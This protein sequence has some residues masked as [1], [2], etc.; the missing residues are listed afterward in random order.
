MTTI[1][2]IVVKLG[3]NTQGL[4]DGVGEA[5][6]V[7]KKFEVGVNK[8]TK[9]LALFTA[10]AIAAGTALGV[11]LVKGS[12]QAT[13]ELVNLSRAANTNVVDFQRMA[14]GASKFGIEQEKLGDILKDVNDRVG[15]FFSTGAGPMAD[16]FE[17]VA[18]KIGLTADAFRGL[19]GADAL[20]LYISSLEEANLN[21]QDMTFYLEA[22]ASDST[23]LIPLLSNGGAALREYS[24]EAERLGIIMSELDVAA[25]QEA[26]RS[27]LSMGA[28]AEAAGN[29]L[30]AAL[31]PYLI[32]VNS[33]IAEATSETGGFRA[34]SEAMIKTVIYGVAKIGDAWYALVTAL[35]WGFRQ[36][37]GIQQGMAEGVLAIAQA[38]SDAREAIG[39]DPLN[40]DD[41]ISQV[42]RGQVEL[43]ALD[44][45]LQLI[46][47]ETVLPTEQVEAFFA[48]VEAR[49][50]EIMDRVAADSESLGGGGGGGGV[51]APVDTTEEDRLRDRLEAFD[52]FLANEEELENRQ[53]QRR[54]EELA[55]FQKA[56]IIT[57]AGYNERR[58]ALEAEHEAALLEIRNAGASDRLAALE[59]Q[60]MTEE[61]AEIARYERQQEILQEAVDKGLRTQEEA[62]RISETIEQQHMDRI[63]DIR[64]R[65][66]SEVQKFMA[67]SYANQ[68]SQ[69]LGELTSLTAGVANENKKMFQINKIAG[70]ADAMV[71]A[72]VGISKTMAAYPYPINI[73]LAAAHA[74]AAFAQVTA[75]QSQQYGS[76]SSSAPSL[77][78][79]TAATPVSDV[80]G[81]SSGGQSNRLDVAITGLNPDDLYRGS[82]IKQIFEAI[83]GELDDGAILRVKV[84]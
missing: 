70:I 60:I 83:N 9:T 2:N 74:A 16:F 42:Q 78:G 81:S 7:L 53:Y 38:M 57:E 48:A 33:L 13:D 47:S 46:A 39:L 26:H 65:G 8:G 45:A 30:T 15:D 71:N 18:P 50:Q 76:G 11:H 52:D 66:M 23:R 82:A 51:S 63:N 32:E 4:V 28:S 5:D 3:A 21:Q 59:E 84:S 10:G 37:K 54:L 22:M 36:W 58:L 56:G 64:K 24:D 14:Y 20:Q 41:M 44:E 67:M 29:Q 49:R 25:V 61:E 40:L 1:G 35:N 72:Y 75:I 80:G 69:V 27:F 43:D 68:A 31:A 19:S 17:N 77:A 12:M 34:E 73:G 55:S 6:T 62:A 79:G